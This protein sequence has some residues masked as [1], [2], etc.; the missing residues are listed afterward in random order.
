M[1]GQRLRPARGCEGAKRL[2]D[3]GLATTARGGVGE[4]HVGRARRRI[5]TTARVHAGY[6]LSHG[7]ATARLAYVSAIGVWSGWWQCG[8]RAHHTCEGEGD[9]TGKDGTKRLAELDVCHLEGGRWRWYGS[10][11]GG[12]SGGGGAARPNYTNT[13]P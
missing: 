5:H 2:D 7:L 3:L 8:C 12:S 10:G 13:A 4:R 6:H 9:V 1:F 11:G